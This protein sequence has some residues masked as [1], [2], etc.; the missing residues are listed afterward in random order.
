MVVREAG[1][2]DNQTYRE[3]AEVETLAASKALRRIRDAELY[4]KNDCGSA[5]WYLPTAQMLRDSGPTACRA[6]AG[7]ESDLNVKD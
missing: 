1:A 6:Q 2:I 5:T 3:R 7:D 4:T